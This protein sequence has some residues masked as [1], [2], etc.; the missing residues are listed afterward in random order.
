LDVT[1]TAHMAVN[2]T[3]TS[4]NS[5]RALFLPLYEGGDW[6]QGFGAVVRVRR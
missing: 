2:V 3:L 1:L 5:T 4:L 6:C